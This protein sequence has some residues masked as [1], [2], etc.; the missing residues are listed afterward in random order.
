MTHRHQQHQRHPQHQSCR[1]QYQKLIRQRFENHQCNYSMRTAVLQYL[2]RQ[3]KDA[4]CH[5][6]SGVSTGLSEAEVG[7]N[8]DTLTHSHPCTSI[9]SNRSKPAAT[10]TTACYDEPTGQIARD[11]PDVSCS[12]SSSSKLGSSTSVKIRN[13]N[14][15]VQRLTC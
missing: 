3:I 14:I 7:S 5:K 13:T 4:V 11:S 6:S 8:I 1:T 9:C 10:T 15:D 12:S 2:L